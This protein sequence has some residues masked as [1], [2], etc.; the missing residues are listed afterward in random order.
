MAEKK[1]ENYTKQLRSKSEMR[2]EPNAV[3]Q[4]QFFTCMFLKT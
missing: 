1:I 3:V 2:S 4:F